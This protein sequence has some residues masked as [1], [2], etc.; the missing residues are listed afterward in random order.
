MG[1]ASKAGTIEVNVYWNVFTDRSGNGE[2]SDIVIEKQMQILNDAFAG[3]PSSYEECGFT[4]DMATILSTPFRFTLNEIN[5]VVDN[6]A[7]NLDLKTSEVKRKELR[8]GTC[9]DLNIFSGET[10]AFNLGSGT[11]S[12]DCDLPEN[13]DSI[14]ISYKSL[15]EQDEDPYNEGDTLIR[16]VG[17]W[18][19]LFNTF[20]G[21]CRGLDYVSD[22]P[23]QA[24]STR[25]CPIGQDTCDGPGRDPIHN[26]M[27]FSD[28]CCKYRFTNGQIVRM[29]LQAGM[30][31]NLS[32]ANVTIPEV[33]API[34]NFPDDGFN[35][36][37]CLV[38]NPC[39][40]GDGFC[41][42]DSVSGY[43]TSECNLDGGDCRCD[44]PDDG[45]D[46]SK[47]E[48][49]NPCWIGNGFCDSFISNEFA[50]PACNN[51]GGDCLPCDFPDDG[52]DYSSC[53]VLFVCGI[54]DG[55]C[56]NT[57]DTSECNRDG[58]DCRFFLVSFRYLGMFL[59]LP[60]L[61]CYCYGALLGQCINDLLP[62][63]I[64]Q[65]PEVPQFPF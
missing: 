35:Y 55:V 5:V 27:D 36:N 2:L 22:T 23:A 51:D 45:F 19:G 12:F 61:F 63:W 11:Y 57:Y 50:S 47:C 58:R 7:F 64:I 8:K 34:C 40:V 13:D 9:S 15:P 10:F 41:D 18:L 6:D 48:V 44:F 32:A 25:G 26:F 54:G 31:R 39:R 20:E 29:I 53:D 65:I 46:Y 3:I 62:S 56:D 33:T 1:D 4:Y 28:D 16:L 43:N 59:T 52:F 21:G 30:Y 38:D 37:A 60:L 42:T 14:S 17:N 49:E 24:K